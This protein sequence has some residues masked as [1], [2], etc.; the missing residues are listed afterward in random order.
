M[1]MKDRKAGGKKALKEIKSDISE[2]DSSGTTSEQVA[3]TSLEVSPKGKQKKTPPQKGQSAKEKKKQQQ[4]PPSE[5]QGNKS[6][7]AGSSGTNSIESEGLSKC[8]M[9]NSKK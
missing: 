8:V 3:R 9:E 7:Q 6:F 2:V 5:E 1:K 4:P